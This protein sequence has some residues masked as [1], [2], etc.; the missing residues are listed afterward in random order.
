ADD[1]AAADERAMDATEA[2]A[3]S[4]DDQD[5]W[6]L[7][8][9]IDFAADYWQVDALVRTLA[10]LDSVRKLDEYDPKE[11][12]LDSPRGRVVVELEGGKKKELLIGSEVPG[13][14]N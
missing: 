9:P 11:V 3:K 8:R 6:R 5:R 4:G 2:T 7:R 14:G 10:E 13:S 1:K 12:G